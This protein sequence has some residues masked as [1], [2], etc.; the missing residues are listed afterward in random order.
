MKTSYV[1][2]SLLKTI[3][4][5]VNDR[6]SFVRHPGV[7]FSRQRKCSFKDLILCLLTMEDGSLNREMRRFFP[8]SD[9][10]ISNSAFCQQRAK[11]NDQAL[12]FLLSGINQALPLRKKFKGYH[13]VAVD[14]SDVDI[15]PCHDSPDTFVPSNTD[16]CGYHQMH[17]N[18]L[19]D[20]LEERYTDIL[21]QPRACIN[22]RSA[23]LS[24]LN[25]YSVPGKTIFIADRGYFSLNL[26][27]HLLV[28]GHK[29][30]LRLNSVDSGNSFLKRFKLPDADKFDV[31]LKFDATRSKKKCYL[32]HPDKFIWLHTKRPFDFIQP[33]DKDSLFHFLVRLVKVDLPGGPEYLLTNLSR[34]TFDLS[35]LKHL[36]HLRWGIETSFRFLKYNIALTSFHSIRRDFIRQEIY[37]RV[38]MYNLTLLLTH[39]VALSTS[40]GNY[41]RKVSV[42]D[43][44]HTCRD[45]LRGNIN[46][47]LAE[48]LLLRYLTQIRPDRSFQRKIRSQRY[49]PLHYRT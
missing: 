28:S 38:I 48:R 23:F 15:P 34:K 9:T 44:V 27:A 8:Q 39:T 25:Y 42:S 3:S 29:F 37:A 41:P 16:G 11:L 2:K 19:Y 5:M 35:G 18:A 24:L 20:L 46:A 12:P 45:L 40:S 14:G 10:V 4:S 26:L 1:K 22:E 47:S 36:Y 49:K 30:L 13:L 33:S 43:A 32:E 7:D 6:S 21:V 31:M 17:L